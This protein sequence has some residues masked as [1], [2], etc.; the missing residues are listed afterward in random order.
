MGGRSSFQRPE[1]IRTKSGPPRHPG[2][3]ENTRRKRLNVESRGKHGDEFR[4]EPSGIRGLRW[5][6][7]SPRHRYRMSLAETMQQRAEEFGRRYR[8]VREEIGRVIVGH[9][10][11]VHG[12]QTSLVVGRHLLLE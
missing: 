10:D 7:L 12:V 9:D 4:G 8:A 3:T 5:S 2:P 1:W 11:I 6:L